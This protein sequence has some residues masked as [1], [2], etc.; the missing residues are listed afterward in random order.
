MTPRQQYDGA[1]ITCRLKSM[2]PPM[3]S[4]R[5]APDLQGSRAAL[6]VCSV[7]NLAEPGFHCVICV[8]VDFKRYRDFVGCPRN[9]SSRYEERLLSTSCSLNHHYVT[10][11]RLVSPYEGEIRW[12]IARDFLHS[13]PEFPGKVGCEYN[14]SRLQ[15]MIYLGKRYKS[16]DPSWSSND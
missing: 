9:L 6:L 8:W 14:K 1:A 5:Q 12:E 7:L 4:T 10:H 16:I 13:M 11:L 15:E 2:M 3:Y